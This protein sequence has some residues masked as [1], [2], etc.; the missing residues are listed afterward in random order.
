MHIITLCESKQNK[1]RGFL[2]EKIFNFQR[3]VLEALEYQV[4]PK[5]FTTRNEKGTPQTLKVKIERKSNVK[6]LGLA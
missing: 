4:G 6:P 1:I 5:G 3:L 2:R